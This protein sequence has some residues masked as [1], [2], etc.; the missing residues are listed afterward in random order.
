MTALQFFD[1]KWIVELF[2]ALLTPTVAGITV[3]IAYQQ[4]RVNKTR[5]DVDLYDRRLAIY[6]AVDE[7]YSDSM[8]HGTIKFP[9]AEKLRVATAEARFLFPKTVEAH[10]EALHK[11]AMKAAMLRERV[12]PSSG[13]Q[14]L[15]VGEARSKAVDEESR[16]VADVQDRLWK[17]SKGL[18]RK[19]LRLV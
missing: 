4:W 6:K 14:G 15:P 13:E 10:L 16:L 18:F 7:F 12:Y 19:Y 8:T 9:M 11:Q 2:A 17:E 1:P 3:Y 5:L